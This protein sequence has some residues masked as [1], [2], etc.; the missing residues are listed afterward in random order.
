MANTIIDEDTGVFV[1]YRQMN[2]IPKLRPFW[3]KYFVNEMGSLSQGVGIR[4]EGKETIYFLTHNNI[5]ENRKIY[6]AYGRIFVD[7][8]PQKY[9]PYRI[10]LTVD[11]NLIKYPGG[12]STRT[13]GLTT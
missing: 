6:I 3:I 2:K 7:Y 11:G 9:Y 4:V 8:C 10:C 1:Y 12:F 13:A 5:P